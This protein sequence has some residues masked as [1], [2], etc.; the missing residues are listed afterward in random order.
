MLQ[1]DFWLV[2]DSFHYPYH[3]AII[4]ICNMLYPDYTSWMNW[5]YM[6][7]SETFT[8]IRFGSEIPK[9]PMY[10]SYNTYAHTHTH[11]TALF[12]THAHVHTSTHTVHTGVRNTGYI[13]CSAR[14]LS[15]KPW[16]F[17]PG[18]HDMPYRGH[19]LQRF[20]GLLNQM[21]F[22]CCVCVVKIL[23]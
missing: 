10:L 15:V 16:N 8:H 23:D 12:I 6:H 1:L 13:L 17:S 18:I 9:D 3:R 19:T 2:A 11:I 7:F 14:L 21:D 20:Q 22:V 5:S 4:S